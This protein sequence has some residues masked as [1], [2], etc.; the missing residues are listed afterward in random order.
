MNDSTDRMHSAGIAP[1]IRRRSVLGGGLLALGALWTGTATAAA[2][3]VLSSPLSSSPLPAG[4][5]KGLDA[6]WCF[7]RPEEAARLGQA[8]RSAVPADVLGAIPVRAG[9]SRVI[10]PHAQRQRMVQRAS[11]QIRADFADGRTVKVDGWVLSLTEA[12]LC[13][14]LADQR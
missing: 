14:S 9:W 2:P 6:A 7:R 1:R 5:S 12:R 10:R 3:P 8:I 11:D 4:W 13:A